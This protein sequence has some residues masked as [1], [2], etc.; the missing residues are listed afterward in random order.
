MPSRRYSTATGH[1]EGR[2]TPSTVAIRRVSDIRDGPGPESDILPG[3]TGVADDPGGLDRAD[4][5]E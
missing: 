5:G 1:T 4:T 3:V 2:T